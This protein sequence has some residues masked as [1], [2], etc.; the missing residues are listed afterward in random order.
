M[1]QLLYI[2]LGI[3][4]AEELWVLGQVFFGFLVKSLP[5]FF[6]PDAKS[7]QRGRKLDVF[8]QAGIFA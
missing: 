3:E 1:L 7:F 5:G 2:A 6:V 4:A 8:F